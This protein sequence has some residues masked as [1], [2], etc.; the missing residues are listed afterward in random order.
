MATITVGF[1]KASFSTSGVSLAVFDVSPPYTR[2]LLGKA[3][4]IV[5]GTK[6][7]EYPATTFKGSGAMYSQQVEVPDGAIIQVQA[8]RTYR[9]AKIADAV[10][11]FRTR[12]DAATRH[13]SVKVPPATDSLLSSRFA[14]LVGRYDPVSLSDLHALGVVPHAGLV[15]GF[16]DPEEIEELFEVVDMGGEA[17]PAPEVVVV[18][19]ASGNAVATFVAPAPKRRIRIR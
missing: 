16:M 2:K 10:L 4:P 9:G 17:A 5:K 11:F 7:Q 14:A 12:A 6:T 8:S 13:C 1:G 19:D 18:P 3:Y 15:R